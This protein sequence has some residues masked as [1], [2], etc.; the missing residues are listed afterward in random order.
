MFG[1]TSS[2]EVFGSIADMLV[3]LFTEA[4]F[5]PMVKWVDDFFIIRLPHQSWTEEEFIHF[6]ANLGVPWSR[7]KLR[8]FATFQCYIGFNWDLKE[9]RVSFPVE[10]LL[11][12]KDLIN[13]WLEPKYK[14]NATEA[15]KLHGKLVHASSIFC[16]LRPFF[17][18]AARFAA[19]IKSRRAKL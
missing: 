1:L 10:K 11:K 17:R 5:G 14:F 15:A 2:A 7:S 13:E 8:P 19:N 18:S 16:L 6:G 9:K 12:L 3:A 4:G